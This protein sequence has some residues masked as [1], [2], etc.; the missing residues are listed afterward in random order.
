MKNTFFKLEIVDYSDWAIFLSLT[1]IVHNLLAAYYAYGLFHMYLSLSLKNMKS[2]ED[3][4]I[5]GL[6]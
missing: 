1:L 2:V 5:S 3:T 6:Y 4:I